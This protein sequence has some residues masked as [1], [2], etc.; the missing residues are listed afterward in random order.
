M[1]PLGR[2]TI[3]LVGSTSSILG[4]AE[5]LNLAV[6]RFGQRAL[7][8]VLTRELWPKGIHV[9]H[10]LIDADIDEGE[11][12]DD[13]GP[14]ADPSHITD[15]I[16]SLHRQQKTAWTSEVDVRPWNEQFWEHC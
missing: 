11:E 8:Q 4:R 1:V 5:H 2:G 9:A 15:V 13:G 6:G 10:V 14:Q 3:I 7:A 12:R 16:V